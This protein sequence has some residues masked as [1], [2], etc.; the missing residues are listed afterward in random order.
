MI[1]MEIKKYFFENLHCHNEKYE[2][3]NEIICPPVTQ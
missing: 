1:F 2:A 3:D